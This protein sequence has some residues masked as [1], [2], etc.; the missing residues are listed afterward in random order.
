MRRSIFA[1]AVAA[2]L[3]AASSHARSTHARGLSGDWLFESE[4]SEGLLQA[5]LVLME[6]GKKLHVMLWIDNHELRGEGLTD[7]TQ[8]EAVLAHADGD[9]PG[10]SERVNLTGK[11]SGDTISGSFDN[12]VERGSWTGKRKSASR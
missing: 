12:G 5:W 11:L 6:D 3:L 2:S 7:G 9:G 8:F 10:H 1:A 4:T